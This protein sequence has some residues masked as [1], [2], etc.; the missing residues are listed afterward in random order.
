LNSDKLKQKQNQEKD[1][2]KLEIRKKYR[3]Q[4]FEQSYYEFFKAAVKVLEPNTVWSF[5]W[6]HKYLCDLLQEEAYRI[7]S[8]VANSQDIIST[9]H[10]V[11]VNL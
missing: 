10:H 11:P 8:N 7:K 9:F 3:I 1:K 4:L 6:H 5:N 2:L